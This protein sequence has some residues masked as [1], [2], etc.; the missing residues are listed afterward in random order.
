MSLADIAVLFLALTILALIPS[1][2]VALVVA[3][4]STAGFFN[5]AAVAAGI[6]VGDLLFVFAAVLGMAALAEMMGSLF[7]ILRYMAGAYLIWFG[8]S[9][10]QSKSSSPI[11]APSRSA[12]TLS[13][14]FLSGLVLTLGDVKAILFY[15]S[16]FPGF[17]DLATIKAAD[18]FI[19]LALTIVSVGGVKLGYAFTARGIVSRA[20]GFRGERAVKVI[21]GGFMVGVGAYLIS[22]G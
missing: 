13:A 12:S 18:I 1:A 2:S 22:R 21:T 3:R 20:S 5:G 16:L 4:S 19:I 15:A 8:L 10:L 9:L 7:L 11:K 6:V 17:V 14:S